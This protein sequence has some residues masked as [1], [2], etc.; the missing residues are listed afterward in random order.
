MN[1][2]WIV[3]ADSGKARIFTRARKFSELTEIETLVHPESRLKGKDLVTDRPAQVH[4][5][6]AHGQS[7]SGEA[8]PKATEAERFAK[9]LVYPVRNPVKYK[10]T[11]Q[12]P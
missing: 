5:S 4:E 3:V 8:D 10:A 9:A 7:P 1:E 2:Y 11:S 12:S 6:H